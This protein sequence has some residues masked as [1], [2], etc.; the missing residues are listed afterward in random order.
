[1][2]GKEVKEFESKL[3]KLCKD[4]G[5]YLDYDKKADEHI[6]NEGNYITSQIKS[7]SIGIAYT[8]LEKEL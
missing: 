7:V 8:Y 5:M 3:R 2:K 4:Y 1:M 6:T